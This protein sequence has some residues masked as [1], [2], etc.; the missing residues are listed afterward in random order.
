MI[1][2]RSLT[3][4]IQCLGAT[5]WRNNRFEN[6]F[7]LPDGMSYNSYLI[8]DEKVAILDTV[9]ASVRRS[10]METLRGL[11]GNTEPDY[12]VINHMEPDHCACILELTELYP[13]MKLVGTKKAMQLFEQFYGCSLPDRYHI[14]KDGDVLELGQ[15]RLRTIAIPMVHW[16]EVTATFEE[17]T[18]TL[19]SADAFGSFA[20]VTGNIYL[21]EITD[22]ECYIHEARRY[23]ANI[24]GK[25]GRQVQFAL[26]KFNLDLIHTIAPLHGLI[27]RGEDCCEFLRLYQQWSDC[28]PEEQGVVI[29]FGSMYGNTERAVQYL[30]ARLAEY[31]VH[32]IRVRDVTQ[33]D[34]SY[35]IS[36]IWRYSHFVLAAPTYNLTLFPKMDE[37][38]HEIVRLGLYNR[39]AAII[40]NHS[41][42]S[43]AVRLMSEALG[44]LKDVTLVMDPHDIRSA[45]QKSDEEKLDELAKAIAKELVPEQE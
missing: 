43:A 11:L 25:Y 36:D 41:W 15:H 39:R 5:D 23:Y 13:N 20:P 35:V 24:I 6:L 18:G 26:K 17:H 3:E 4:H 28:Q 37:L 45:M 1:I 30:T 32:G 34:P 9:D 42:A 29:A 14:V 38:I 2:T 10:Y 44:T 40:G 33:V 16:P 8:R 7:P 22:R 19:F 12:L 31:G 27:L 21:D